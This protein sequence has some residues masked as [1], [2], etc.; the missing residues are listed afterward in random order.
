VDDAEGVARQPRIKDYVD[1]EITLRAGKH[2][3]HPLNKIKEHPDWPRAAVDSLS[4]FTTALKDALDLMAELEGASERSDFS[5]LYRPSIGD[6][7]QNRDF[8]EWT[9][10]IELC[11]DA[12]LLAAD[13]EP[14]LARAEFKRWKLIKYPLFRRLVFFAAANSPLISPSE[15]LAFLLEDDA[16]WLWS[17]ETQREAFRLLVWLAPKLDEGQRTELCNAVLTGVSPSWGRAPCLGRS[18]RIVG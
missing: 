6:H 1:W 2:L 16:W 12:W 4:D 7:P 17:V 13:R 5:Y 9:S 3:S 18:Y 14:R 15:A 8:R 10:L 11:R